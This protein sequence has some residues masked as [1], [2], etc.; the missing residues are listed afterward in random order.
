MC[1]DHI[2]SFSSIDTSLH[3]P[4]PPL[5]PFLFLFLVTHCI[6]LVLPVGVLNVLIAWFCAGDHGYSELMSAMSRRQLFIAL[7]TNLLDLIFY[8]LTF[9][10]RAWFLAPLV[11]GVDKVVPFSAEQSIVTYRFDQ[12]KVCRKAGQG[13]KQHQSMFNVFI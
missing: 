5:C 4:L 6:Q 9:L 1:H 13:W 10:H 8:L 11:G 2:H 7:L 12:L 3:V